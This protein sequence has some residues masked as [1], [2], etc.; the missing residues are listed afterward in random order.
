MKI[1]QSIQKQDFVNWK[2]VPSCRGVE[3]GL[4]GWDNV[5]SLAGFFFILER[6]LYLRTINKDS[7]VKTSFLIIVYNHLSMIPQL[8]HPQSKIEIY[9]LASSPLNTPDNQIINRP[10][11][12]NQHILQS[13]PLHVP[14]HKHKDQVLA[15]KWWKLGVRDSQQISTKCLRPNLWGHHVCWG[16]LACTLRRR[17]V[18]VMICWLSSLVSVKLV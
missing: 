4:R 11:H 8:Q 2:S 10:D 1:S 6:F 15:L 3:G 7:R 18:V 13:A 14:C 16:S 9:H 5:P 17:T 12:Q